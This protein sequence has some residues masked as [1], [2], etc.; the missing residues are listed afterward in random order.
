M[1][2]YNLRERLFFYIAFAI[3]ILLMLL[4]IKP[5]F[6]VL[7]VSLIAV[8]ML[9]PLYNRILALGWVRER[10]GLAAS[11]T[12]IAV[13]VAIIIPVFL[14]VWITVRQLAGAFEQL[15][16]MDLDAVLQQIRQS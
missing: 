6:T 1:D 12:L 9:K 4:M 2:D 5:F 11:L 16:A 14:V 10:K 7:V 8:I 15:A 3:L 13:F